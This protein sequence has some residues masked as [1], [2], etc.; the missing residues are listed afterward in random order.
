MKFI[1]GETLLKYKSRTPNSVK[2]KSQI[3][4]HQKQSE[5]NNSLFNK[6]HQKKYLINREYHKQIVSWTRLTGYPDNVF[7]KSVFDEVSFSVNKKYK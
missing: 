6:T 2:Y 4:Y 7:R 5:I 1:D 3:D